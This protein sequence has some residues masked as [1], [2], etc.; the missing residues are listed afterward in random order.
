MRYNTWIT[1]TITSPD[2]EETVTVEIKGEVT[3]EETF[4]EFNPVYYQ[5][6]GEPEPEWLSLELIRSQI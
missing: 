1:A 5:V 4:S 6:V 2:K 3:E